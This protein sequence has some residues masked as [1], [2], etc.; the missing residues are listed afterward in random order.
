MDGAQPVRRQPVDRRGT[1]FGAEAADVR[2]ADIVEHDG[3]DIGPRPG[4][5][6][7]ARRRR[8]AQRRRGEQGADETATR[9]LHGPATPFP[10]FR[11]PPSPPPPRFFTRRPSSTA[12]TRPPPPMFP[13]GLPRLLSRTSFSSYSFRTSPLFS[14]FSLF[15]FSVIF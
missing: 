4:A 6:G 3:D 2:I 5:P 11:I 9:E 1:D 7:R 14:F 12:Y 10:R 13:S 15:S 8:A